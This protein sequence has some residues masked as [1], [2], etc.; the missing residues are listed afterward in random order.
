MQSNCEQ[1]LCIRRI[2]VDWNCQQCKH[3][4]HKTTEYAITKLIKTTHLGTNSNSKQGSTKE[5]PITI[6]RSWL[7]L[8]T[9]IEPLVN[10]ITM[11]Y[12]RWRTI[13]SATFKFVVPMLKCRQNGKARVLTFLLR[14]V[15]FQC[16][17]K[18]HASFSLS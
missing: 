15:K 14:D 7:Q 17:T 8:K 13:V 3:D 12:D 10:S 16:R 4:T 11:I 6:V 5:M 9:D 1:K 18:Y 2:A